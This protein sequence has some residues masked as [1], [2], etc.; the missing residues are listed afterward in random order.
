M[1]TNINQSKQFEPSKDQTSQDMETD[2]SPMNT[3]P[4]TILVPE[5]KIDNVRKISINQLLAHSTYCSR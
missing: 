1:I 5:R 3:E 4:Q 2:T